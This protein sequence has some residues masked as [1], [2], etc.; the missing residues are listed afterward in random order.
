MG[1]QDEAVLPLLAAEIDE[2]AAFDRPAGFKPKVGE[3][4]LH[5]VGR[6]VGEAGG[7]VDREQ[8]FRLFRGI[9]RV[10]VVHLGFLLY[11]D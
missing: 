3:G 8:F 5:P 11:I 6:P 9:F 4:I 1:H 2:D 7:A 10:F